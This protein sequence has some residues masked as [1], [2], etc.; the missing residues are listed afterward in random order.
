[1]SKRTQFT[2]AVILSGGLLAMVVAGCR[3]D[4]PAAATLTPPL[5]GSTPTQSVTTPSLEV[6]PTPAPT[7][8]PLAARAARYPISLAEYEAEL[9]MAQAA[10]GTEL[11]PQDAETV[12]QDLIDQALLA[13]A[14]VKQGFTAD[15]ALIEEHIARMVEQLGSEQALQ[16]WYIGFKYD[17]Q[18]FRLALR[19]SIQAAWM[20]DRIAAQVPTTAEQVHVRQILLYE[21]DQANEVYRLLE[22]GNSFRNLALQ[23]DPVTGGDLGWFPRG[24]LPHPQIEEAAFNLDLEAYSPII[25]TPAGFHILQLLERD[26]ARALAPD[27]LLALQAKA[28]ADW[29]AQNRQTAEIEVLLP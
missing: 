1:M 12:L 29:L 15:D 2:I 11:A 21:A 28:V 7:S 23:Y 26:S 20:R 16:D 25:E 6:S 22:S 5:P 17:D 10:R 14:A 4:R 27:A 13:E 9:A 18:T 24:Y 3:P 8:P 19:R